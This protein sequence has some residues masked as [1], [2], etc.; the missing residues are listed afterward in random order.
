MAEI[1]WQEWEAFIDSVWIQCAKLKY[2]CSRFLRLSALPLCKDTPANCHVI[3]VVMRKIKMARNWFWSICVV[4]SYIS[5][6]FAKAIRQSSP[7]FAC[8]DLLALCA[9]YIIDDIDGDERKVV[10]DFGESIRSRDLN[11]VT[12]KRTSFASCA[13]IFKGAVNFVRYLL[14]HIQC[15]F[16]K[17]Q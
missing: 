9:G 15:A 10:S 17:R 3:V 14:W 5:W 6:E 16:I 2:F 13:C 4:F 8:V 12:N 7:W 1:W 11:Y